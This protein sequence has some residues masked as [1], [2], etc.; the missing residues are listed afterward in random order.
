MIKSEKKDKEKTISE[1]KNETSK[2][3]GEEK[4]DIPKKEETPEE[5]P[6]ENPELHV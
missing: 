2:K 3:D 1:D 4:V 6:E 5:N